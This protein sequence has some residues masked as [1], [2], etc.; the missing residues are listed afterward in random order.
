MPGLHV[1]LDLIQKYN[2]AG[3]RYTSYPP[4]TQFRETFGPAEAADEIARAE[5]GRGISLYFH[6]PFCET[7]CWFCG[8]TT[9]IT[10]DHSRGLAY[11]DQLDREMAL[12]TPRLQSGRQVVQLHWGG[13]TPTFLRPDEIRRLGEAIRRRFR[14]AADI[15]A[16]VEID[17]RRLTEDHVRAL[18]E[19]G[20]NRASLGVQDFDPAVQQ[21]VH[22]IQ[23]RELTAQ[24]IA[25]LRGA[26]FQS[27]NVDLIYGLPHQSPASFA[28]TLDAVLE[29][30][31]DRFAV[32]NYAHVPWM[33]PQQKIFDK[34]AVLPSPE[35]KLEVLKLV[36]ERLTG[37]AGYVYIG[38]DHFARPS[39]EL[40]VAQANRTLQRNFQGYS[41]RG[42][43]DILGFGM[44]AISQTD[45]AYWQNTKELPAY[46]ESVQ[47]GQLPVVRGCRLSEDDRVRRAVIMEI[48]CNLG[49]DY[50]KLDRELGNG[51]RTRE[52]FGPEID[53]LSDM[54]ADGLLRRT[55]GGIDITDLGRLLVRN[56]AMRFDAYLP[57][58]G[59]RRFSKTI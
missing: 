29:L 42:G 27:V 26:G 18:Q 25:W 57:A 5:P 17:P 56:I 6:L 53:G 22:R 44:S 19:A 39:D 28:R 30:S 23:S 41:T 33:K 32:F 46:A 14:F 58:A 38:M 2:V 8:C 50:A 21:A 48:M 37:Q 15:E 4:A 47:A 59:E 11:V 12:V 54:E 1:D 24:A 52:R 13:G 49:L 55:A 36:T 7:L 45:H 10:L 51:I 9:V 35:T 34:R 43:S 40:A 16:S 20:F 31:P 3:P